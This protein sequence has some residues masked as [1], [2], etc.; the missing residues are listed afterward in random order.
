MYNNITALGF[1][2]QDPEAKT[3]SG[4]KA[5]CSLRVCISDSSAKTKTFINA[6]FWDKTAEACA[7]YLS[8]GREVLINGELCTN[9]WE[10]KD[11]EK[12]SMVFIRGNSVKFMPSRKEKSERSD[13]SQTNN[14]VQPNQQDAPH[15]NE[16][17]DDDIPF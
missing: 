8:K 9:E 4:G 12:K 15:L 16:G 1:L 7:Q 10:G 2:A 6:E 17:D 5:K 3:T 14:A 13:S 11:G